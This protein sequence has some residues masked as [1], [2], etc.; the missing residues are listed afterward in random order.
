MAGATV[1][2]GLD[3]VG[4]VVTTGAIAIIGLDMIDV[5]GWE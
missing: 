2:T 3:M 5:A 1:T 4:V